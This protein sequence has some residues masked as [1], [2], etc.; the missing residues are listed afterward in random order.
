MHIVVLSTDG[1]SC[2]EDNKG[3][4][5]DRET[6]LVAFGI[7]LRSFSKTF[8]TVAK[9]KHPHINSGD[10]SSTLG[11]EDPLEKEM[12]THSSILDRKIPWTQEPVAWATVPGVAKSWTRQNG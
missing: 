4:K 6:E 10:A 2:G 5:V 1:G 3:G 7:N 8:L 12:A 9:V 11:G